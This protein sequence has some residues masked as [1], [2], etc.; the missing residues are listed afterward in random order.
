M[1][2]SLKVN[3]KEIFIFKK[4][5]EIYSFAVKR[6]KNFSKKAIDKRGKFTVALSGGR[7]PLGFYKKL[8]AGTTNLWNKTHIFIADERFVLEGDPYSNLGAIR[9]NLLNKVSIPR[10]NIHSVKI[11]DSCETAALNYQKEIRDFFKLKTGKLPSFD[12]IVL[13]IGVDGHTVSLFPSDSAI[14]KKSLTAAVSI[15]EV[16]CERITLT[17]PVINN[18]KNIIF[19]VTGKNK[20]RVVKEVLSKQSQKLPASLVE[21]KKG[22]VFFLLDNA[23]ASYL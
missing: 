15:G 17:L 2:K 4:F 1:P 16:K 20:G 18:A 7:T 22:N 10:E 11:G 23:A 14:R 3:K 8:T 6:W 21:S 9:K 19:I 13:G 5:D 12:L